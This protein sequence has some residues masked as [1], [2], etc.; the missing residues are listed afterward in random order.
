MAFKLNN[1]LTA[2]LQ[3][4]ASSKDQEILI[5]ARP[6]GAKS[7]ASTQ[8]EGNM[9]IDYGIKFLKNFVQEVQAQDKSR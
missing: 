7:F 4:Y 3:E 2:R 6:I 9:D 1:T 5:L 8:M